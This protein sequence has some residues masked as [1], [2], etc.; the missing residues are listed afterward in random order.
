VKTGRDGSGLAVVQATACTWY[1]PRL[2]QL[3]RRFEPIA[4]GSAPGQAGLSEELLP[5]DASGGSTAFQDVAWAALRAAGLLAVA[6]PGA[7]RLQLQAALLTDAIRGIHESLHALPH[8]PSGFLPH[9]F[10]RAT[11]RNPIA[12]FRGRATPTTV[13]AAGPTGNALV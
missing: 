13:H 5:R 12:R 11:P 4:G 10:V 1:P 9:L 7:Q 2:F 6:L 8:R 3:G